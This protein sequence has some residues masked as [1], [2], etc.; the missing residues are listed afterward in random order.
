MKYK[1]KLLSTLI[2]ANPELLKLLRT[3]IMISKP[4][5]LLKETRI[6]NTIDNT[7]K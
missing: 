1:L 2:N 6:T 3:L 5:K 7:I 4:P